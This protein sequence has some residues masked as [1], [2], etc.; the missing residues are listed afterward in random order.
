M[1]EEAKQALLIVQ[2]LLYETTRVE[3]I[4]KAIHEQGIFI[5]REQIQRLLALLG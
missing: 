3:D 5:T 2:E 1:T 4:Y